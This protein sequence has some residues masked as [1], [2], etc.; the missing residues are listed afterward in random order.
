MFKPKLCQYHQVLKREKRADKVGS[1]KISIPASLVL[2]AYSLFSS[3]SISSSRMH[4]YLGIGGRLG[5]L[6][7]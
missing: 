6:L 2:V 7:H 4:A 5:H 3:R 1:S